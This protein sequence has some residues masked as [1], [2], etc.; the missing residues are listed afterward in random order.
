MAIKWA[1]YNPRTPEGFSEWLADG[2]AL[3]QQLY[4]PDA[5][6]WPEHERRYFIDKVKNMLGLLEAKLLQLP[7]PTPSAD[8]KHAASELL[9]GVL[10]DIRKP[11]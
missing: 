5:D 9:Q 7:T 11:H 3:L 1:T 4:G 8:D 2:V 6:K 10:D